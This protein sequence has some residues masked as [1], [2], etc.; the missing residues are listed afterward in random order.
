MQSVR[1]LLHH[2]IPAHLH[3]P[4][5]LLL[6]LL[7]S[8]DRAAWFAIVTALLGVLLTPVDWLLAMAERR[9]YQRA[10]PPRLPV[11]FVVGAPRTGTTLVAQVLIN[12]LPVCFLNNLTAVFPRAPIVANV[13]LRPWVR[14][15][16]IQYQSF[17]GKSRYFSGPNDGLQIW[18]RWIGRERRYAPEVL[19][20]TSK[21]HMGRFFGAF[22]EAF[23]RPIVNKNNSLSVYA[24]LIAEV[25][26]QA[27]FIC[28]TRHPVYLAQAFLRARTD[29]HA[30]V[31][32]PY[33]VDDPQAVRARP[34]H[35]IEDICRH[36]LFHEKKIK[37]NLDTIGPERFWLVSYE[38][39]CQQPAQLVQ[40]VSEQI[41][42]QRLDRSTAP[43]VP[44]HHTN[45]RRIDPALF[46]HI[47]QTLLHLRGTLE[48]LV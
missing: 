18:D 2:Y 23:Q 40:R 16:P 36:V 9:R 5:G 34:E 30:D 31:S 15:K 26:G 17:Y 20:E 47:E 28:M 48:P 8:R 29:M 35:Y 42:G 39:F 4:W 32:I 41:L 3:H 6:R 33:G 27:Y 12:H 1:Q 45:R 7:R 43:C 44:F 38:E 37:E 46:A 24:H 11:I 22:E 14:Q 21:E 25:F 10:Q 13:L 19:D